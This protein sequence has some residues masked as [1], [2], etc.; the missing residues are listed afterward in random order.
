MSSSL[1]PR[2][3]EL[4]LLV[5]FLRLLR[6]LLVSD[7]LCLKLL[8]KDDLDLVTIGLWID[9]VSFDPNHTVQP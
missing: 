6:I 5:F 8:K 2:N 9:S 4:F 3:I 1:S 7:L